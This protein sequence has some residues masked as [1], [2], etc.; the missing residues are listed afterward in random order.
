MG[1]QKKKHSLLESVV[2]VVVG[3]LVAVGSQI[4]IYPYFGIHVP[5]SYNFIIG[6]WFTII[7]IIRSYCLRRVFNRV[8]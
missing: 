5:I 1:S 8:T 2:N 3:Y 6:I 7:S 4:V